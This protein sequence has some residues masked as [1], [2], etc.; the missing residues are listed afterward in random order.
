MYYYHRN[1]REIDNSIGH[2]TN[3]VQYVGSDMKGRYKNEKVHDVGDATAWQNG[4]REVTDRAWSTA[5]FAV[6][7]TNHRHDTPEPTVTVTVAR[8]LPEGG[9]SEEN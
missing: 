4:E 1:Y 5:P 2:D 6:V 9:I 7:V 3:D 8:R